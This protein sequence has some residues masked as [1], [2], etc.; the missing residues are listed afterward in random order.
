MIQI[1]M[2]VT[3][4]STAELLEAL[5]NAGPNV[6][7]FFG[8]VVDSGAKSTP[9]VAETEDAAT[10]TAEDPTEE[11]EGDAPKTPSMYDVRAALAKVRDKHGADKM[12]EI[13]LKYGSDKLAGVDESHYAALMEDAINVC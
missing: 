11:P 2:A 12:R 7:S 5:A 9:T 8:E 4:N 3:V 10:E 6:R 13:L 1:D